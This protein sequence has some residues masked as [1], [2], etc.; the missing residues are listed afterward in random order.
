MDYESD[1]EEEIYW[2]SL[3]RLEEENETTKGVNR[4]APETPVDDEKCEFNDEPFK[5]AWD[6]IYKTGTFE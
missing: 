4:N 3:S 5:K 1:S 2:D 6:D